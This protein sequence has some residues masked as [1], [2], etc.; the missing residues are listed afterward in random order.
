ML[1]QIPNKYAIIHNIFTKNLSE[2]LLL[3]GKKLF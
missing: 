2:K 3:V 1:S